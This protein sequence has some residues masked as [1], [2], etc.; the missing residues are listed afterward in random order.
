[1][2]TTQTAAVTALGLGV[3]TAH[4]HST[5]ENVLW[6]RL[7]CP[8]DAAVLTVQ[9][10]DTVVIDTVSHEGILEDQGRDPLAF[11]AGFGVPGRDVLEDAVTLAAS[12]LPHEPVLDGPHI[13]TGP[14][15]VSGV[16]AGDVVVAEVVD[17]QRRT[18]YGIISSRHARGALPGELPEAGGTVSTFATVEQ[19]RGVIEA[20]GRRIRFPLRPFLGLVGVTSASADRLHSVPPGPHGGNL[21]VSSL[22]VGSRLLLKAQIDGAGVYVGDPHFS[23]GDGEVALTAFEAPLRATLR[24][25]HVP[26]WEFDAET[27]AALPFGETADLLIPIG[28]HVDLG[29]AMRDCVR[30]S[31]VLLTRRYGIDRATAYAY[32]S[33]AGD[34]SVSQVVDRVC[35][36]HAKIR[37]AD[38]AEFVDLGA[39]TGDATASGRPA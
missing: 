3:P 15:M 33:A 29:E 34:F 27:L 26:A 13:V 9:S 24:L 28:L 10:G 16:R 11:F 38:F 31:L 22:G 36:V 35:G 2:A 20:A 6:G 32:L 30:R 14:I 25:A 18:D 1:M 4:L 23:Q 21:D 39:V 8:E 12:G 19:G 17:L 7:P 37:R 5:P